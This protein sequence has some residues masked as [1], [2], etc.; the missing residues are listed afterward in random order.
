MPTTRRCLGAMAKQL[1]HASAKWK[2]K[3]I[4]DREITETKTVLD[5][6]RQHKWYASIPEPVQKTIK[7]ESSWGHEYQLKIGERIVVVYFVYFEPSSPELRKN[8][9]DSIRKVATWLS[10]IVPYISPACSNTL[11]VYLLLTDHKKQLPSSPEITMDEEHVNTAF[12]TACTKD[13]EIFLY[14]KEEWFKVFVHESFHSL[15]IDFSQ[16]N[17]SEANK[18]F[19]QMFPGCDAA[20]DVRPYEAYTEFWAEIIHILFYVFLTPNSAKFL[21]DSTKHR[22]TMKTSGGKHIFTKHNL[23]LSPGTRKNNSLHK[24]RI[25]SDSSKH[26]WDMLQKEIEL[27]QAFS[28]FQCAKLLKFVRM[29]YRDL[30]ESPNNNKKY[31]EKTNTFAYHVLKGLLITHLNKFVAWCVRN[32]GHR[33]YGL[34]NLPFTKTPKH[35]ADFGRFVESVYLDPEWE[36][37]LNLAKSELDV[38][39]NTEIYTTMR[40]TAPRDV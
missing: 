28:V 2:Q 18:Q 1:V 13:T 31:M 32:N 4:V 11:K 25:G 8:I 12:T 16:M 9:S 38:P 30:I 22:I 39:D 35:V 15:G 29:D 24:K 19:L 26:K 23:N 34:A 36:V 20:M 7:T 27:E 17:M 5:D 14:R 33:K 37:S 21:N 40:M 6:I 10:A 3:I